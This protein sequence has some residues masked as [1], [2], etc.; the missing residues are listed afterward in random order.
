MAAPYLVTVQICNSFHCIREL[1]AQY[2]Q[3]RAEQQS[4]ELYHYRQLQ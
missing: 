3:Q 4:S 2:A 1:I